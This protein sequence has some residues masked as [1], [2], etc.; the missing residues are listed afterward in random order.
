ME[1]SPESSEKPGGVPLNDVIERGRDKG[2]L[3]HQEI[4]NLLD[5]QHCE[6]SRLDELIPSL[7][8]EGIE[9]LAGDELRGEGEPESPD[10]DDFE[11]ESL[12]AFERAAKEYDPSKGESGN[13][14]LRAY[15]TQIG[16]ISLLSRDAELFLAKR[17][18]IVRKQFRRRIMEFL[19]AIHSCCSIVDRLEKGSLV[20]VRTVEMKNLDGVEREDIEKRLPQNLRTINRLLNRVQALWR[21]W[22]RMEAQKI[23][24]SERA[25][26][27]RDLQSCVR[28]MRILLEEFSLRI[29]RVDLLKAGMDKIY[30]DLREAQEELKNCSDRIEE[31]EVLSRIRN[32]E[33]QLCL[34]VHVFARRYKNLRKTYFEYKN[35]KKQLC[36][37]NLRLVISIA[38]NYRGRGLSFL[39][40]IQEGNTGLLKA[41][42]KF[43]YRQ[44]NKFSTY[45]TWWI[46]QSIRRAI[47]TNA[48]TIRLPAH[49]I[50]KIGRVRTA[51]NRLRHAIGTEPTL[52]QIADATGMGI[53]RVRSILNI[54]QKPVS[55]ESPIGD[56]DGKDCS[57]VNFLEDNGPD[58]PQA[59]T[60]KGM[61]QEE[62]YN[63]LQNLSYREREILK[64]RYGL[65]DGN[66]YT[67]KEIGR[68][69]DITRERVRQIEQNAIRQL[70]H[71]RCSRK[72]EDFGLMPP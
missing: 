28:K 63:A 35:V 32:A 47:A 42:E 70:Q 2:F 59:L 68:I 51:Q 44:G 58:S 20:I 69:F 3:T 24:D 61:M 36:A 62:I 21:R 40:L 9:L 18:E 56:N 10:E 1:K 14:L 72:L 65:G 38:K 54:D 31:K 41:V 49:I 16:D 57:L 52:E 37:S 39:D 45:A 67:L 34:P 33:D 46:Q 7:E 6:S 48:R 4:K 25:A 15:L 30:G 8:E 29:Q 50:T 11:C 53:N 43:E 23:T 17:I 64:L 22:R 66:T 26:L 5:D 27:L 71:P 60:G 19:P 55:L 12:T 13:E